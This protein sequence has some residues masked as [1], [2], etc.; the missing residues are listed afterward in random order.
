MKKQL[1]IKLFV[2]VAII[3]S[4]L[5]GYWLF[6]RNSPQVPPKDK[7]VI[8]TDPGFKPFEYRLGGK[9]V[10]FDLDLAQ[11]IAKDAGKQLVVEEMNFDGLIAALQAGKID[12]A[13]AGMSAT[14][15]RAKSVN[16]STL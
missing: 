3:A 7:L 14:P 1:F 4:V 5:G 15:E 11:E 8:G 10:G 2:V 12:L 13:I 16:F 6:N 9:I